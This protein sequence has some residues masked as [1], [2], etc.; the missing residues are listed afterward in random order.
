MINT[1]NESSLHRSLKTLYSLEEGAETE[2]Q[3]D[4]WVCDVVKGDGSVFE[5]QTGS[6]S[7]LRR[8]IEGLLSLKKRVT[9]VYPVICKKT[10][11]TMDKG[12]NRISK[13]ASPKKESVYSIFRQLTGL[14]DLLLDENFCLEVPEITA[15]ECRLRTDGKVQS[16]NKSRRFL[17][18]W[19]KTDKKLTAVLKTH[20]FKT[21]KDYLGLLP[22]TADFIKNDFTVKETAKYIKETHTPAAASEARVTLWVLRRMGLIEEIYRTKKECHYKIKSFAEDLQ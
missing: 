19:I 2:K 15:T 4:R 8:K 16:A 1:L 5:I 6:V 10:I 17:K 13:R 21:E 18:N 7:S 11:E 3:V 14:C 9:L 22:Q 12:G 20:R